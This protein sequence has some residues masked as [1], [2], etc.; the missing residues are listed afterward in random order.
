MLYSCFNIYYTYIYLVSDLERNLLQFSL[1][2]VGTKRLQI[3]YF[4]R[5]VDDRIASAVVSTGAM[6]LQEIFDGALAHETYLLQRA[7]RRVTGKEVG[8]SSQSSQSQKRPMEHTNRDWR[9]DRRERGRQGDSQGNQLRYEDP[10]PV[11][12]IASA[13]ADRQK[14]QPQESRQGR[15]QRGHDRGQVDQGHGP[16]SGDRQ[17]G[18]PESRR[19]YQC[20]QMRHVRADCQTPP[21]PQMVDRA[22]R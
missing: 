5:G 15:E 19:C 12:A 2:V 16:R 1:D 10:Q 9:D 17:M 14:T 22:E 18:R 8:Q 7:G 4:T 13:P 3:Y 20:G 6:T 21:F 11:Y